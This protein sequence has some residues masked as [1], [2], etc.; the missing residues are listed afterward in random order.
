[1]L[2][3]LKSLFKKTPPP[4]ATEQ[5][6]IEAVIESLSQR[7]NQWKGCGGWHLRLPFR[8]IS[9]FDSGSICV[10]DL[11]MIDGGEKVA[12]LVKAIISNRRAR[13]F[14]KVRGVAVAALSS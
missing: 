3:W 12:W 11:P 2:K 14:A 1:M 6:V 13:E 5:Q 4:L 7:P 8:R 10:D 9:V